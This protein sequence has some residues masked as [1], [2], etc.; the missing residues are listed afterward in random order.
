MSLEQTQQIIETILTEYAQIPYAYRDIQTET[1]F[2][3]TNGRY[4]LVNM[5]WE[6][7][8]RIYS[9][10]VHIDI[11]DGKIWIQRDGTEDGIAED[12]ERAGVPKTRI[13]LGFRPPEVRK[14][15]GYGTGVENT[16]E[17]VTLS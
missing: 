15:S 11:I 12:L 16:R 2:D 9:T 6:E 1:I 17:P 10:L 3:K 13:I 7:N 4:L 8:K 14:Y 5:G